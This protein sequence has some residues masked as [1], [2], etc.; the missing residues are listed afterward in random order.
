MPIFIVGEKILNKKIECVFCP[1]RAN[2][3]HTSDGIQGIIRQKAGEYELRKLFRVASPY[4]VNT[5]FHTDGLKAANIIIHFAAPEMCSFRKDFKDMMFLGYDKAIRYAI[6][7]KVKTYVFVPIPYA[8]KRQGDMNTYRTARTLIRYFYNLYNPDYTIFIYENKQGFIDHINNYV[9]DYV[10]TSFPLS[11]RHK[12]M[13]YP[14]INE[15]YLRCFLKNNKY[16]KFNN[17]KQKRNYQL[18]NIH[19]QYKDIYEL[20]KSKFEDDASFC[21]AANISKT[22]YIEFFTKDYILSKQE[23]V[24]FCIAFHF[25]LEE[26]T[27]FLN[28]FE[29]SFDFEEEFDMQV[30][31]FI[32]HKLYDI[33][34]I[35]EVMYASRLGQIGTITTPTIN[36]SKDKIMMI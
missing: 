8:Y 21:M 12:P 31:K 36:K 18:Y 3:Y 1:I 22:C 6:K 35:N 7:L 11:K 17:Y 30:K 15:E 25:S 2:E 28:R 32:D 26:T 27:S 34:S 20:I 19:E 33:I 16:Y 5:P 13:D 29:Y 10:S 9:P 23:V 4:C 24:G 14:F